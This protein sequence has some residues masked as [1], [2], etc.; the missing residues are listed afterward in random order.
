MSSTSNAFGLKAV[1]HLKGGTPRFHEFG[2]PS[3]GGQV[4]Y[5][6]IIAS[7]TSPIYNGQTVY[8]TTSGYITRA[9][10][11][12]TVGV[13]VFA[14]CRYDD[15]AGSH[16]E[17]A[18]WPGTAGATNIVAQ[19]YVDDAIIFAVQVDG[20][21]STPQASIGATA[22]LSATAVTSGSTYS[23]QSQQMLSATYSTSSTGQYQILG[24][25]ATTDNALTDTYPVALVRIAQPMF[26]AVNNGQ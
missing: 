2:V 18:F 11:N 26:A 22:L 17:S 13:G 4:G 16:K 3:Y 20:A 15:S 14:G 5:N 6:G 24:F 9:A 12:T 8:L 19:V 7:D 25:Q 10:T 23:G 21:I 1:G